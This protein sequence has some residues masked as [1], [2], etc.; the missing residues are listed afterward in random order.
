MSIDRGTQKW[1]LGCGLLILIFGLGWALQW[2]LTGEPS[3]R[4][5]GTIYTG[6]AAGFVISSTC[7]VGLGLVLTSLRNLEA[8]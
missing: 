5:R 2:M 8:R 6:W 4:W 7:V 1:T 3:L